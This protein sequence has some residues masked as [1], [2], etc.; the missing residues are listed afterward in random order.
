MRFAA[1]GWQPLGV[2]GMAQG[3]EAVAQ[4]IFQLAVIKEIVRDNCYDAVADDTVPGYG[5]VE[6]KTRRAARSIGD[7]KS[8]VFE[9]GL[10]NLNL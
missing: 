1:E 2:F 5:S 9:A 10:N 8:V 7:K 6:R 3:K 4:H